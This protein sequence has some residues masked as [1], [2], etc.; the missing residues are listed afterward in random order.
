MK[1]LRKYLGLYAALFRASVIAELEY[2]MNFVTRI[3]TDL[4]WYVAQIVTFEVLYQHT[5]K[6]GD[7][8]RSQTRVFL[9]LLFVID[10]IYMVVLHDNLDKFSDRVSKGELD[11]ILAKP[12]NS[13]FMV[14][15]QRASPALLG[16]LVIGSTWLIF[17]LSQLPGFSFARLIWLLVLIPCGIMVLYSCRFFFTSSA[18]ILTRAENLQFLWYQFYKLGMRPD[19]LYAPW[20]KV[21]LLTFVPVSLIASVPA[22]ALLDPPNLTLF[23]WSIVIAVTFLSL[24]TRVWKWCLKYYA[25]ASS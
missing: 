21:I 13:Q 4:F 3:V 10:A 24:S 9:G 5:S 17:S 16:N 18:L 23:V 6:I 11:L 7:W 14:S 19:S 25:S 2:R 20:L 12:V 1:T 22:H 8:D 15:L